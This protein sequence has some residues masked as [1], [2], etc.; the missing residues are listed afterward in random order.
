MPAPFP[1]RIYI[2]SRE[3][4][5]DG[6]ITLDLSYFRCLIIIAL[7]VT[8]FTLALTLFWND[9]ITRMV[10]QGIGV[11]G[12]I[13]GSWLLKMLHNAVNNEAID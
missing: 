6:Y 8:S 11:I 2:S 10:F 9:I 5:D 3:K 7:G 1:E 12:I 4:I 13:L